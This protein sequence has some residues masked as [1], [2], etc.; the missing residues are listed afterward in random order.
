MGAPSMAAT[1]TTTCRCGR[2]CCASHHCLLKHCFVLVGH[3]DAQTAML[4]L[5]LPRGDLAQLVPTVS[6]ARRHTLGPLALEIEAH[7][8]ED[9]HR[10]AHRPG[11]GVE[12]DDLLGV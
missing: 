2:P 9:G 4:A 5:R 1:T 3:D 11:D 8:V 7:D 6:P 10:R 12:V